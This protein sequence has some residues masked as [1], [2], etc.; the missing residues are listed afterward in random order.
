MI[1]K[2][3]VKSQNSFKVIYRNLINSYLQKKGLAAS[4][5]FG[6]INDAEEWMQ[7][8]LANS[9]L[10]LMVHAKFDRSK[11]LVDL[12]GKQLILKIASLKNILSY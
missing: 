2:K 10:E 9:R 7:P 5:F 6:D 3:N 11:Q 12:D 1:L 4:E 8:N